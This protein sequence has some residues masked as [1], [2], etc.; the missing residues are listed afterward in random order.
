[1]L[2]R[3]RR[4]V[5]GGAVY[6][7]DAQL[8]NVPGVSATVAVAG[9]EHLTALHDAIQQAFNWENDHLYSF[10][11]DGQFWGDAAAERV[12]PGAPDTDSKTADVAVDELRLKIGARIA[13]VFDY[14]DD[15]RVMLTLRER[16]DGSDA[17]SRVSARR[18]TAPPQYPP[19]DE[20]QP[21]PES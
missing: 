4:E 17:I 15:W 11:L 5:A 19:L 9:H 18:G 1:M 10:W 16:L 8:L 13:Y 21:W 12:I 3:H 7:F 6:V 20:E 14:G 2:G